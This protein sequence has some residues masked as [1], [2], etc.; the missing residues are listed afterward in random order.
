MF[1]HPDDIVRP[2][3]PAFSP[4]MSLDSIVD[5]EAAYPLQLPHFIPEDQPDSLPRIDKGVLVDLLGG[6]Y[7]DR[8]EN[9]LVIDCR[10]EYEFEGG[11]I[12]GAINHNDK[13]LLS[14]QLLSEPKAGT[15]LVFHCEYSAHRAPIMYARLISLL[16]I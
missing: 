8:F 3:D 10:F 7:N 15:V 9:I 14:M 6:K 2:K 12:N 16:G 13:E 4:D 5:I 11:H 1:E